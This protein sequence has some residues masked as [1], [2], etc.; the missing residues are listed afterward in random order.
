MNPIQL[1]FTFFCLVSILGA[2]EK[3]YYQNGKKISLSPLQDESTASQNSIAS[4]MTRGSTTQTDDLL[5]YTDNQGR[6]LGVTNRI[7]LKVKEGADID[8]LFKAYKLTLDKDLKN[9]IYSVTTQSTDEVVDLAN[10]LYE[11]TD[12]EYAHPDFYIRI[13]RR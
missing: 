3:Y 8:S 10:T 2:S 7:I 12:I 6:E 4:S 5:Y 13:K 1:F 9:G 11:H